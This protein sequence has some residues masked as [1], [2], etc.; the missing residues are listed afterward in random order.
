MQ[1]MASILL[2]S[3]VALGI[4]NEVK[5]CL[6][7]GSPNAEEYLRN[8]PSLKE[9]LRRGTILA[10]NGLGNRV[11]DT[12]LLY[13]TIST[14]REQS[15]LKRE[16]V[17]FEENG[18]IDGKLRVLFRG[19]DLKST[20]YAIKH[21]RY[22]KLFKSNLGTFIH[23]QTLFANGIEGATRGL[24]STSVSME[25][26]QNYGLQTD[27]IMKHGNKDLP[28]DAPVLVIVPEKFAWLSDYIP[29]DTFGEQEC[30]VQ[31]VRAHEILGIIRHE[32]KYDSKDQFYTVKQFE[33]NPNFDFTR[34]DHVVFDKQMLPAINSI[35]ENHV[36]KKKL[37]SLVDPNEDMLA[38]FNS[39]FH[40]QPPSH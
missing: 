11:Y 18:C 21:G 1:K 35:P 33:I 13:Q 32:I 38:R 34:L 26:A 12:P 5:K 31:G 3:V 37:L 22:P 10:A 7:N 20:E 23:H 17:H 14:A 40:P 19:E 16:G 9:A 27:S 36:V 29:V 28:D 25:I 30:I 6:Q 24:V 8:S 39:K 15:L 2:K 4:S